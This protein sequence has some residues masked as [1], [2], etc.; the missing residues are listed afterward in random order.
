MVI[1][2]THSEDTTGKGITGQTRTH[3]ISRLNKAAK[4][5][6]E[7]VNL[8]SQKSVTKATNIDWLEARAY[9][10]SLAGAEDFERHASSQRSTNIDIQRQKWSNCLKQYSAARVIYDALFKS[11]KKELFKDV[12]AGT[13]DPSIRYAAYQSHI[14]RTIPVA[15]V[16][17]N[18]FPTDEASLVQTVQALDETAFADENAN[19][20]STDGAIPN[21]ITWRKRKAN[22][23]DASIGQALATVETSEDR[24]R[25]FISSA[26]DDSTAVE[27]AAAYD[28]VLTACQDAVDATRRAIDDHEKEGINESDPRMQDLRITSL[29]VNYGLVSWRVGRNRVLIGD[30]DGAEL[31]DAPPKKLKQSR[32]SRTESIEKQEGNGRKLARLRERVVLYDAIL[33]SI[34]SVTELPGA[35]EISFREEL[36]GKRAYFQALKYVDTKFHVLT[37]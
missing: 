27:K 17:R 21:I 14:P 23:V 19:T 22:I 7:L 37:F 5:A 35:A 24:L 29:A 15:T 16:A 10:H 8:L 2:A 36:D 28:D 9:A 3:I 31:K 33:Q 20:T 13:V 4:Q 11:T 32:K 26:S 18:H 12:L 6:N 25:Q 30:D 34:D 1:K